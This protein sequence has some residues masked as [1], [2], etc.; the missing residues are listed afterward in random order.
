MCYLFRANAISG[1]NVTRLIGDGK[2]AHCRSILMTASLERN[3]SSLI[4]HF[5]QIHVAFLSPW[6]LQ[7]VIFILLFN[8]HHRCAFFVCRVWLF[9]IILLVCRLKFT[10]TVWPPIKWYLA[11]LRCLCLCD[12]RGRARAVSSLLSMNGVFAPLQKIAQ[13]S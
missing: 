13:F 12:K 3:H 2:V 5:M 8:I 6:S 4:S 9:C 10:L 7:M 11:R 1:Q